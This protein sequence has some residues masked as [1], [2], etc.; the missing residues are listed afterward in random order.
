[1]IGQSMRGM[2]RSLTMLPGLSYEVAKHT[3][4]GNKAIATQKPWHKLVSGLTVPQVRVF[5]AFR[6]T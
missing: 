6:S 1:M 5:C 4:P 2:L 3:S